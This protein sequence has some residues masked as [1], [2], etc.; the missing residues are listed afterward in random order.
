MNPIEGKWL[1][2]YSE[3]EGAGEGNSAWPLFPWGP[4]GQGAI[5]LFRE[6]PLVLQALRRYLRN[7]KGIRISRVSCK[8]K[9]VKGFRVK[10]V[11]VIIALESNQCE[12]E[13]PDLY[14]L[15]A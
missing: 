4:I 6:R 15:V 12:N 7:L 8:V 2:A 3:A 14:M 1:K 5:S 13:T 10:P 11:R 9:K